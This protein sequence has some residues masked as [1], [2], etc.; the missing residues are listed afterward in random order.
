LSNSL[1]VAL[2]GKGEITTDCWNGQ[3]LITTDCCFTSGCVCDVTVFYLTNPEVRMKKAL[4]IAVL[5]L[6]S[7]GADA[8]ELDT[9]MYNKGNS[10]QQQYDQ[11]QQHNMRMR[12]QQEE[13]NRIAQQQLW[14]QQQE[15]NKQYYYNEYK[16]VQ[17]APMIKYGY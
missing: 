5:T 3:Q 6:V 7:Q 16:P 2:C 11:Q 8:F 12:Q 14:L 13:A 17:S 15:H 10:Q 9:S 1:F 4:I